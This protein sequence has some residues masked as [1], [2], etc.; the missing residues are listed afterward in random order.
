M[1]QWS[2]IVLQHQGGDFGPLGRPDGCGQSGHSSN[3]SHRGQNT[4]SGETWSG[5]QKRSRW[6]KEVLQLAVLVVRGPKWSESTNAQKVDAN[7]N[8]ASELR[9]F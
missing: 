7:D 4:Q 9:P 5:C 6:S 1:V 3:K 8:F 2:Q